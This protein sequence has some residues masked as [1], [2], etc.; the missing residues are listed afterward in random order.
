MPPLNHPQGK[1]TVF[2]VPTTSKHTQA[3]VCTQCL[4]WTLFVWYRWVNLWLPVFS[5]PLAES[6]DF[7]DS[8]ASD[9][10]SV[11]GSVFVGNT[12]LVLGLLLVVLFVH[13]VIISAVEAYW[14]AQVR[15]FSQ[16]KEE[17]L[18]LSSEPQP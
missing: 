7:S 4:P 2:L 1:P 17:T 9:D 12:V 10:S 3:N 16:P 18:N 8:D 6:C 11:G 15:T 14:L 13:V 5:G